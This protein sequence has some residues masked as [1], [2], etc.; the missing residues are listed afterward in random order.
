MNFLIVAGL[1]A[2]VVSLGYALY[3]MNSDKGTSDRMARA[4][5]WRVTFSVV[6]FVFLFV[7]WSVGWIQPHGLAPR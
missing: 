7:A 6:L 3:Y 1:I 4:L 5:K 2:V